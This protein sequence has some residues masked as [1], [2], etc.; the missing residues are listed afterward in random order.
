MSKY[1]KKRE[2]RKRNKELKQYHREVARQRKSV[3]ATSD[4]DNRSTRETFDK[5]CEECGDDLGEYYGVLSIAGS[6]GIDITKDKVGNAPFNK[7]LA[8]DYELEVNGYYEDALVNLSS[9]HYH[10]PKMIY[11]E[12]FYQKY[13]K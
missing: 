3:N 6:D 10:K 8:V 5:W 7:P 1:A 2:D 9:Y 11:S 12:W 13:G 4:I